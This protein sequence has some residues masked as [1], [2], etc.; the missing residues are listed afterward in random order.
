M[1]P[2]YPW[3]AQARAWANSLALY[4]SQTQVIL[5][6]PTKP[7]TA[8]LIFSSQLT[9]ATSQVWSGPWALWSVHISI[10]IL[11][12]KLHPSRDLSHPIC[13]YAQCWATLSVDVCWMNT[14]G[15]ITAFHVGKSHGQICISHGSSNWTLYAGFKDKNRE[16]FSCIATVLE[17]VK[18]ILECKK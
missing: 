10:P 15:A 6:S 3:V 4:H 13:C 11:S 12:Y 5:K 2:S 8:L 14:L 16:T 1:H 9:R 17:K 7:L 18:R